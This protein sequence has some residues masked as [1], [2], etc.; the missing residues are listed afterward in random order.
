LPVF[1]RSKLR[2]YDA[3]LERGGVRFHGVGVGTMSFV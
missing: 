1:G 3:R 2:P